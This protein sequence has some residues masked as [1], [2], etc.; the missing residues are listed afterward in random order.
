V[1]AVLLPILLCCGCLITGFGFLG[2]GLVASLG[3]Q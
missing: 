1:L 2:A 3:A